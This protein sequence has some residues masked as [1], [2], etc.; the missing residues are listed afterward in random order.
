[1]TMP[2][3]PPVKRYR[4]MML[5]RPAAPWRPTKADAQADAIA[6]GV[7]DWDPHQR[8]LYVTVPARIIEGLGPPVPARP[9]PFRP[10]SR[11]FNRRRPSARAARTPP[12]AAPA[13]R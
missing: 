11:A 2:I 8:V 13:S 5:Q 6:A 3:D 4:L 12:P 9:A 1:M 7:A 10:E